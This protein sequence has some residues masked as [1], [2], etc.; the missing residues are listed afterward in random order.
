MTKMSLTHLHSWPP[1]PKGAIEGQPPNKYI[2]MFG[3]NL[4]VL[5]M[6]TWMICDLC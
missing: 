1:A 5:D 6:R 3:I 4:K 2:A